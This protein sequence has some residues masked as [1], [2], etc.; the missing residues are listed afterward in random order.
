MSYVVEGG[1]GL[2][3]ACRGFGDIWVQQYTIAGMSVSAAG[4]LRRPNHKKNY[5]GS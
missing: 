5:R 4:Q 2:Y 1:D 3:S